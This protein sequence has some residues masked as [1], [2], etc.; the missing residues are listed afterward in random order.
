MIRRPPRSTLFPYTTLFRSFDVRQRRGCH[1]P[2]G[3]GVARPRAL[4]R[5]GVGVGWRH[6]PP[7]PAALL[8]GAA[9][10]PAARPLPRV[11]PAAARLR[12][13]TAA[14]LFSTGGA[15]FKLCGFTGWQVAGL[16]GAVA[17]LVVLAL[18]PA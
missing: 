13:F 5:R 3:L 11:S 2:V 7:R 4:D 8:G 6:P 18:V 14:A 9:Q 12:V 10:R 1:R 15:A 16:R 17:A